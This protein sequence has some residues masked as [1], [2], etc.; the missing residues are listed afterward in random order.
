M[1]VLDGTMLVF[2]LVVNWSVAVVDVGGL[3][4]GLG[5]IEGG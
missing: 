2:S 3:I 5:W 4:V 1:L